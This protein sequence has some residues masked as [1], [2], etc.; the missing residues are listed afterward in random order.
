VRYLRVLVSLV[1]FVPAIVNLMHFSHV[2]VSYVHQL[3][4][5]GFVIFGKPVLND[6]GAMNVLYV[7]AWHAIMMINATTMITNGINGSM[8]RR[9][10]VRGRLW[11]GTS[12]PARYYPRNDRRTMVLV[13]GDEAFWL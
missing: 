11:T 7:S 13:G 9:S 1:C 10:R 5:A 2:V 12:D 8:Q 3:R 6:G 4:P